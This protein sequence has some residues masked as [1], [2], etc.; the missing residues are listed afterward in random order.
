[1]RK[2]IRY[3]LQSQASL[4][5]AQVN[6]PD[7]QGTERVFVIIY[8]CTNSS[9]NNTSNSNSNNN[10]NSNNNNSN[11][12]NNNDINSNNS[13]NDINHGQPKE[14]NMPASSS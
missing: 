3:V 8:T 4:V 14:P 12:N 11:S 7:F 6:M 13:N 10:I 1:M 5:R 9:S 2:D